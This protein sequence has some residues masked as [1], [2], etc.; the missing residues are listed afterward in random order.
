[1]K[2]KNDDYINKHQLVIL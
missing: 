1:M 2:T